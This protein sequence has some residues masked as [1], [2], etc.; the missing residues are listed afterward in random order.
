MKSYLQ[1]SKQYV[2]ANN[3]SPCN[4]KISRGVPQGSILKPIVFLICVNDLANV[5]TVLF[6]VLIADDTYI[7]V[8]GKDI[9]VLMVIMNKELDKFTYQENPVHFINLEKCN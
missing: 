4:L 8:D 3:T 1:D 6:P 7:F 9:N 2:V 5:C